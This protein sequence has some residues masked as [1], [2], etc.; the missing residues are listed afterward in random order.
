MHDQSL[1]NLQ[2]LKTLKIVQTKLSTLPSLLFQTTRQLKTLL[3]H[4]NNLKCLPKN[5]FRNLNELN[6]LSLINNKLETLDGA[7]F[8]DD[9]AL[10][11]L[12]TLHLG[13]NPLV[14]DCRLDGLISFLKENDVEKSGVVCGMPLG[15]KNLPLKFVKERDLVCQGTVRSKIL[16]GLRNLVILGDFQNIFRP[17]N[18]NVQTCPIKRA[19]SASRQG[20]F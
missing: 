17:K 11:E 19:R 1:A 8:G 2:N 6:T 7:L 10:P 12:K 16:I 9:R 15:L 14:C 3:L 5:I 13:M 18:R 20:K 4:K